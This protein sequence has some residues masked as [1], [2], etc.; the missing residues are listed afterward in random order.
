MDV[1]PI[2]AF[3]SNPVAMKTP[4][5]E[6]KKPGGHSEIS[7][8]ETEIEKE[9]EKLKET[10]KQVQKAATESLTGSSQEAQLLQGIMLMQQQSIAIKQMQI[11]EIKSPSE[12]KAEQIK[13]AADTRPRFDRFIS[14]NNL[15]KGFY[16]KKETT[17]NDR[18][19]GLN[20]E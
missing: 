15:E 3:R 19:P 7:Q 12:S 14:T 5:E 18:N 9:E 20:Q 17:G 1:M 10:M 16:E 13:A 4:P 8:L 2:G 6:T 11:K